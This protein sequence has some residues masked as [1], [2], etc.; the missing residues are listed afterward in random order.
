MATII[1]GRFEQQSQV[2]AAVEQWR[3]AGIAQDC[4]STFYVTQAGRHATFP[5]GG[6][7]FESPGAEDS[8]KGAVAG[9]ATGGTIG[10]V[11]GAATAPVTGPLGA[12][13][14]AAVGAYVGSLA[15]SM[16]A[17][18]EDGTKEGQNAVPV[19]Q[20]G[21]V[22]AAS[23]PDPASETQA[24]DILRA[25]GA[26]DIERAEGTIRDGNWEDFDPI[27]PPHLV[28]EPGTERRQ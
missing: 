5:V 9:A 8:G 28:H 16:G 17:M 18:K 21:M 6:D 14:G 10:A 4:I 12:M 23:V 3:Q 25:L 7:R 22:A 11:A 1:A 19:R 26:Q 2:Q 13:A 15:G 27:H 24:I 20:A